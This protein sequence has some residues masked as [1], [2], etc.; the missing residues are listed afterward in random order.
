MKALVF[1]FAVSFTYGQHVTIVPAKAPPGA[2]TVVMVDA[3]ASEAAPSYGSTLDISIAVAVNTNRVLYACF[4]Q[5]NGAH[6]DADSVYVQS[7]GSGQTFTKVHNFASGSPAGGTEIWELKNPPTGSLTI[8]S[9]WSVTYGDGIR[10]SLIS[11]YAV[12]Q[13]TASD[14]FTNDADFDGDMDITVTSAVN[15]LGLMFWVTDR[16]GITF[17]DGGSQTRE[18]TGSRG[19]ISSKAGA[20]SVQQTETS[21]SFNTVGSAWS[22]I[23]N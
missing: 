21:T 11:V 8:R 9:A 18:T 20:A 2:P 22:V 14:G 12:N 1:L 19:G 4:G 5:A 16:D 17:T 13:T 6:T 15:N 3:A 10:G 7:G 23:F